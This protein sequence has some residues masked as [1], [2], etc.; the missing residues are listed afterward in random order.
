MISGMRFAPSSFRHLVW[1]DIIN[2]NAIARPVLRLRQPLVLP[3]RC[4]TVAKVL[5]IG[6]VVRIPALPFEMHGH[7]KNQNRK[8]RPLAETGSVGTSGRLA[9][10]NIQN[11]PPDGSTPGVRVECLTK[12]NYGK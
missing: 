9:S 8:A 11:G 2:L 3:V 4:R 5:S 12:E 1:V 10:V 7:S 6:L